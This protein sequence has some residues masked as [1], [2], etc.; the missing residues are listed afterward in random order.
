MYM[1]VYMYIYIYTHK[2][3]YNLSIY[4][5]YMMDIYLYILGVQKSCELYIS[6]NC[7]NNL[8]FI[9]LPPFCFKALIFGL[10]KCHTV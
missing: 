6:Y 3:I 8:N 4:N 1:Y 7:N 5:V 9:Y 10:L 2:D